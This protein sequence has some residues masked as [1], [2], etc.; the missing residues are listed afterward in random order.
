MKNKYPVFLLISILLATSI[1]AQVITTIIGNGSATSNGDGGPASQATCWDPKSVTAD[2]AGNIY[3]VAPQTNNDKIRK[4][5]ASNN[6][7]VTIAGTGVEGFSGE[8]VDAALAVLNDP[9]GVDVDQAGN[10]YICDKGNFRIRKIDAATNIITTIAGNGTQASTG[11][12][13]LAVQASVR[14]QNIAV[15]NAGNVFFYDYGGTIRKIDVSDNKIYRI[16]GD[17]TGMLGY[18][19]DGG[20]AT[21]AQI[22]VGFAGIGVNRNNGDLYLAQPGRIRKVDAAT[23]VITTVAGNGTAGF[24]GDGGLPLNAQF[25]LSF[26]GL[27]V[28]AAGNLFVADW[29]NNCVRKIDFVQ[30]L[31]SRVAGTGVDASTGDGGDPLLATFEGPQG[32]AFDPAGN[33]LVADENGNRIRKISFAPNSVN[34]FAEGSIKIYYGQST[35]ALLFTSVDFVTGTLYLYNNFA[36]QVQQTQV[37][38]LTHKLDMAY[39]APGVYFAAFKS[40][41]GEVYTQKILRY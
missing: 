1:R 31:V 10:I 18:S 24:S 26:A 14:P 30:N 27:R 7:V 29:G 3:F 17:S 15:D 35:Q 28:D 13:G 12:G 16:A 21:L 2:Q 8:G 11:D 25:N 5:I 22:S 39:C 36:Q 38:G 32:L 19:G 34:T 20:P 4:I 41:T 40:S 37:S 33:L 6:T 9:Y 23:G